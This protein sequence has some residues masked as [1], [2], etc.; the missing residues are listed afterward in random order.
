VRVLR[1]D[2]TEQIAP[3]NPSDRRVLRNWTVR[4]VAG[5]QML[6][7]GDCDIFETVQVTIAAEPGLMVAEDDD[8]ADTTGLPE[9]CA[10]L[11]VFGAIARLVLGVDLARQQVNTVEAASR[12]ERIGVG[13]GT[14]VSRYFQ[15]LY[16]DR[17]MAEQTRLL[18][19][20]PLQ[21]LRRR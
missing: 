7:L 21:L 18:Q 17:L 15:A 12:S 6:Q 14:Q 16:A 2:V 19:T 5:Q 8:F 11:M 13:S 9:S 20:Y 10:D 3:L 4:T 1:V